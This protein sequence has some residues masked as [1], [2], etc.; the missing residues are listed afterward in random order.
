MAMIATPSCHHPFIPEEKYKGS[1]V[2]LTAP[3][4]ENFNIGAKPFEKHWLM[5]MEPNK[6]SSSTIELIDKY[7]QKRLETL[8]TIDDMVGD[9]VD[10]LEEKGILDNTFIIFTSDNGF[11]LG[12]WAMPWDKRLPYETDIKVPLIIRGPNIPPKTIMNFPVL[13]IDLAPTILN[14][15]NISYNISEFDGVAFNELIE[16][17]SLIERQMLIEHF[18]EGNADSWSSECP[19]KKSQRLFGC[20]LESECKAQDSWN[21]TYACIRHFAKDTNIIFCKFSDREEYYE[22]YDLSTD[23][24]QLNNVAFDLLPSIQARYQIMIE[25]LRNCKGDSCRVLKSV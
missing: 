25:D 5:T 1:F 23:L 15:A 17:D 3:R 12:N 21:N 24:Y 19:W 9:I 18:G 16:N 11:H 7:Y 6:L 14:W 2:N 20:S 22:A 4:S 8:L 13:L 10:L